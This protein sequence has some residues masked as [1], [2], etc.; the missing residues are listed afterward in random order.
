[1]FQEVKAERVRQLAEREDFETDLNI[2]EFDSE[3]NRKQAHVDAQF[4]QAAMPVF[5]AMISLS[6]ATFIAAFIQV[7][8]S[9]M[10]TRSNIS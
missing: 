5:I 7:G 9:Q 10:I 4:E 2:T 6:L 8:I 1:M 3:Y